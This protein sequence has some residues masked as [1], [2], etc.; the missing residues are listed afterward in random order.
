MSMSYLELTDVRTGDYYSL[1]LFATAG[2]V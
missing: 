1:M 2:M